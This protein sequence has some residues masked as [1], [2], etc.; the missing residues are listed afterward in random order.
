MCGLVPDRIGGDSGRQG[1]EDAVGSDPVQEAG[2][3]EGDEQVLLDAGERQLDTHV[4]EGEPERVQRVD[5]RQVHL[6][7]R[8]DVEQ[9]PVDRVLVLRLAHAVQCAHQEVGGVGEEQGRVVS[10]DHEPGHL[11][12]LGVVVDVVHAGDAGDVAEDAVVGLDD[13]AQ[14]VEHRQRDRRTDA[15]QHAEGQDRDRGPDGQDELAAAEDGEPPELGDVDEADRGVHDDTAEGRLGEGGEHRPQPDQGGED[16]RHRHQRVQLGPRAHAV[17]D[18]RAASAGA[19]REALE[20]TDDDVRTAEGE[21]LLVAVDLLPPPQGE[22]P[23]GENVVGVRDDRHPH[24]RREEPPQV[25]RRHLGDVERRQSLWHLADDE[26]PLRGEVEK[27]HHR[28]RREHRDERAGPVAGIAV[29]GEQHDHR[30]HS[31]RQ[32]GHVHVRQVGHGEPQLTA[33]AALDLDAH[34]LVELADDH[35]DR[36]PGHVSDKDGLGQQLGKEAEPQEEAQEAQ[37]THRD[38]QQRRDVGG[39]DRP[40]SGREDRRHPG[41][42]HQR[43]RRLR[44]DGELTGGAEHRVHE[45]RGEN[46]PESGDGRE[47]GDL[48][49]GEN[50]GDEVGRDGHSRHDVPAQPPPLVA[51]QHPQARQEAG[52]ALG[53]AV[54]VPDAPGG[55]RSPVPGAAPPW[56]GGRLRLLT[57]GP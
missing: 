11:H 17:G 3:S 16:E 26:D 43:G 14:Q 33:G 48:G 55:H 51:A 5:R 27:L 37:Q 8:L 36:D 1:G 52:P 38:G 15:A 30:R 9:Q 42:G 56:R 41:R 53:L 45:Q 50:L 35:E 22:G 21:E 19:D 12:R 46:R 32:G 24:R 10:V 44:T 54:A 39:F 29:E 13:P 31:Q 34:D 6:G 18:R 4:A 57:P 49:I 28:G 20:Q 40:R 7:V 23:P 47:T 2:G 25:D